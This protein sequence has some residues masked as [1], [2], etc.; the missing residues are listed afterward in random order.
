MDGTPRAETS[1]QVVVAMTTAAVGYAGHPLEAV[2]GAGAL[3]MLEPLVARGFEWVGA[4]LN[5]GARKSGRTVEGLIAD[6]EGSP[7]K[8]ELLIKALDLARTASLSGKR[9]ALAEALARGIASDG[10]AANETEFLRVL[11][12]LDVSHVR[13]LQIL[14]TPRTLPRR[15]VFLNPMYY[16]TDDLDELEPA[17]T[18]R[19]DRVL[20]VLLSH[21]LAERAE[22]LDLK[23]SIIPA[24][25]ITAY[26]REVLERLSPSNDDS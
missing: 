11:A 22:P 17:L 18:G 21:G 19:V 26:G 14:G 9:D 20:A 12:D 15:S 2:I 23:D 13:A 16:E 8:Q 4:V 10:D 6:L 25:T 5:K 1:A 3:A 24:W 7:E